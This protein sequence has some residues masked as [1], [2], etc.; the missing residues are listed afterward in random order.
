MTVV[1]VKDRLLGNWWGLTFRFGDA[2]RSLVAGLGFGSARPP[3]GIVEPP[4][5]EKEAVEEIRAL[6]AKVKAKDWYSGTVLVAKREAVLLTDIAGEASKAFHV[7][8]NIDTKFN[9][10]SMNKMFTSDGRRPAGRGRE[11]LLRRPDR[12]VDRRNLAAQGRH[13]QDHRP[14]PHHPHLRAGELFQRGL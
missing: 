13:G 1:I 5:T 7:P 3:V 4:L 11:A 8:N 2:P 12:Q 9:L 6:M 10:G 14:P